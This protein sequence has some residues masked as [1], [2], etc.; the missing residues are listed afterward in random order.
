MMWQNYQLDKTISKATEAITLW[1]TE[2]GII[3]ISKNT[4][5]IPIKLGDQRKGY[6]F[7]G[8]S[9]LLLDTIV[10]TEE[11]AIGKPVEKEISEPFLMLGDTEEIQQH[12]STTSKEDFIKMGYENQQE[13]VAKAEDLYDQ[14]FRGGVHSRQGLDED[15]GLIFAFQNEASRLD[16]L[17]TKDSKLVYKAMGMVFVSNENKVVLKSPTAVVCSNN[18]KS[19]IMKKGKSVI[20]K[21]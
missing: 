14:F 15:N 12:L 18:R 10:E 3:E 4:L 16:I 8:Q 7:H 17:V 9:K 19:V 20:V 5:A 21:K 11:G 6:I 2:K 13:F 1:Q